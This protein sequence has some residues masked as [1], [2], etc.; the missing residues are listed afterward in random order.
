[1]LT[2]AVIL[3]LTY[4][5]VAFTRLP[6]VNIDRPSAAFGGAVLMILFGVLT[7]GE[8]VNAIDFNTIALLLGMMILV[9]A[10]KVAGFFE[11]TG[12]E[13]VVRGQ[14]AKTTACAGCG[15]N[16]LSQRLPC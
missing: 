9:A 5:G 12:N 16:C 3:I 1:M 14:D 7:F 15:G 2:A 10:L 4:I 11:P 13:V 6:R 8:A